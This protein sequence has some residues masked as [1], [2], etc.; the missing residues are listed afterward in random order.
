MNNLYLIIEKK[1]V[2]IDQKLKK[3]FNLSFEI[4][5]SNFAYIILSNSRLK[6]DVINVLLKTTQSK[7]YLI[8][9]IKP[10]PNI[11]LAPRLGTISPFNSKSIDIFNIINI[12]NIL[13]FEKVQLFYFSK[14]PK[15]FH[16]DKMTQ[17]LIK[18]KSSLI[19]YYN[20]SA[21]FGNFL[22]D[23][24]YSEVLE[25]KNNTLQQTIWSFIN[26]KRNKLFL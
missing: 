23:F 10:W 8:D 24:E 5:Q 2:D 18:N 14:K 4:K 26:H 1:N 9:K 21:D 22:N 20:T 15:N 16:Y 17:S 12:K 25:K 13:R 11:I 7:L 3:K 6:Q 19:N